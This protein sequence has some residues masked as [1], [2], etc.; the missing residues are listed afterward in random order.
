M[1]AYA[2]TMV[3]PPA[4]QA[5]IQHPAPPVKE[6]QVAGD[7]LLPFQGLLEIGVDCA[8]MD[9]PAMAYLSKMVCY[10]QSNATH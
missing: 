1:A 10:V 4:W 5:D 2:K 8:D 3:E 7:D 9:G 6:S